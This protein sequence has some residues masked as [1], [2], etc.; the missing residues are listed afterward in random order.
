M[1]PKGEL[2][3]DER[4]LETKQIK[5]KKRKKKSQIKG[6][7]ALIPEAE[8]GCAAHGEQSPAVQ[9]AE[10]YS[11]QVPPEASVT[12]QRKG[13]AWAKAEAETENRDRRV[14]GRSRLGMLPEGVI[15]A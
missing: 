12:T 10:L 4:D 5:R 13:P 14:G 2:N 15:N 11:G 3:K 9:A 6:P 8:R 7:K 1:E